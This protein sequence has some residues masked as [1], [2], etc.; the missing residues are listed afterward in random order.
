MV[1]RLKKPG[2][3]LVQLLG[4][5]PIPVSACKHDFSKAGMLACFAIPGGGE[6]KMNRHTGNYIYYSDPFWYLMGV[7]H[8]RVFYTEIGICSD[9][10]SDNK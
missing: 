6:F 7:E 10:S 2:S 4:S 1:K 5:S 9:A 8:S 3:A